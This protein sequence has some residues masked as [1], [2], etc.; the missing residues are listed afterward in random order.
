M[1]R[2]ACI[3]RLALLNLRH[4][5]RVGRVGRVASSLQCG[6]RSVGGGSDRA[7]RSLD[8]EQRQPEPTCARQCAPHQPT[9]C[10]PNVQQC[11]KHELSPHLFPTFPAATR[12]PG[13]RR[14]ERRLHAPVSAPHSTHAPGCARAGWADAT[15]ASLPTRAE[16]VRA[17]G[18]SRGGGRHSSAPKR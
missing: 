4:V 1:F 8:G 9:P 18:S 2:S 10:S 16:A 11:C 7:P 13:V 17:S 6:S 12:S 5:G 14:G 3:R 15:A